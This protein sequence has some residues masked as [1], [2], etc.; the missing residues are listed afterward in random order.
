MTVH[1]LQIH[2]FRNIRQQ[3][4]T[5]S[6][7]INIF[8]GNNGAGKTSVLE[9]V[10]FLTHGRAFRASRT[11]SLV[12]RGSQYTAVQ[13][14]LGDSHTPVGIQRT[15]TGESKISIAGDQVHTLAELVNLAPV[16]VLNSDAFQLLDGS[17]GNRRQF[18]D[19]GVFHVEQTFFPAWRNLQKALKSRNSLLRSGKL[20]DRELEAWTREFVQFAEQVDTLREN[21]LTAFQEAFKSLVVAFGADP[22]LRLSY[23]RGWDRQQSLA[24]VLSNSIERDRKS[25]FTHAGPQRADLRIKLGKDNAVDLLSRGQQKIVVSALKLAQGLFL[26]QRKSHKR[27][28]Y[29]LDDLPAELDNLHLARVCHVL[30][31]MDAQVFISCIDPTQVMTCWQDK[32]KVRMFHVEHG[33][34]SSGEVNG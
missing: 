9:A 34:V 19:W 6:P 20:D 7:H 31:D 16:Q 23:Y 3:S 26:H 25:G 15:R 30:E 17:P 14:D 2:Q 32:N 12:N 1:R 5:P 10:F 21:Y 24:S 28:I 29:L 13:A 27:C 22:E 33:E 4:L 8:Y 11:H 18:L